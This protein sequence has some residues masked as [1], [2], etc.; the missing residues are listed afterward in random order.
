MD[1]KKSTLSIELIPKIPKGVQKD[2]EKSLLEALK[3][4]PD[5]AIAVLSKKVATLS[6]EF[7]K[8]ISLG[9]KKNLDATAPSGAASS[10]IKSIENVLK[11]LEKVK[12]S[13]AS[14]AAK[15]S[16]FSSLSREI[17]TMVLELKSA[18]SAMN[19]FRSS[20]AK[21]SGRRRQVTDN[22]RILSK[23]VLDSYRRPSEETIETS[24][25]GLSYAKGSLASIIKPSE[26]TIE[27]AS[28]GKMYAAQ[29][30]KEIEDAERSALSERKKQANLGRRMRERVEAIARRSAAEVEENE[31]RLDEKYKLARAKQNER[32]LKRADALVTKTDKVNAAAREERQNTVNANARRRMAR[33]EEFAPAL[34]SAN[35]ID[36]A[37]MSTRGLTKRQIVRAER[38]YIEAQSRPT[39]SSRSDQIL[40]A[41]R[42]GASGGVANDL[43]GRVSRASRSAQ[44]YMSSGSWSQTEMSE[45]AL[46]RR[47]TG[48]ISYD[49]LGRQI[50]LGGSGRRSRRSGGFG[51]SVTNAFSTIGSYMLA[52]APYMAAG[53]M[54]RPQ[55]GME[56]QQ[57][58]SR[59]LALGVGGDPNSITGS[60]DKLS[61]AIQEVARTSGLA[62]RD[63][64]DL[65]LAIAQSGVKGKEAEDALRSLS[66]ATKLSFGDMDA[67]TLVSGYMAMKG[68]FF[69][70]NANPMAGKDAARAMERLVVMANA[71]ATDPRPLLEAVTRIGASAKTG[72]FTLDDLEAMLAKGK[73]ISGNDPR[74]LANAMKRTLSRFYGRD[75]GAKLKEEFGIDTK[76]ENGNLRS[77]ADIWDDLSKKI[78]EYGENGEKAQAVMAALTAAGSIQATHIITLAKAWQEKKEVLDKTADSEAKLAEQMKVANNTAA[79][80]LQ[81]LDNAITALWGHVAQSSTDLGIFNDAIGKAVEILV[82]CPYQT[83]A[84]G[85]YGVS[86]AINI[87]ASAAFKAYAPIGAV[88][89]GLKLLGTLR[90]LAGDRLDTLGAIGMTRELDFQR[91]MQG[92]AQKV[93]AMKNIQKITGSI[94]GAPGRVENAKVSISNAA[95]FLSAHIFG[96]ESYNYSPYRSGG[97]V[98]PFGKRMSSFIDAAASGDLERKKAALMEMSGQKTIT[99]QDLEDM[100]HASGVAKLISRSTPG[101]KE[102]TEDFS[103]LV[104]VLA[105]QLRTVSRETRAQQISYETKKF[106]ASPSKSSPA[107]ILGGNIK[108]SPYAGQSPEK[109]LEFYKAKFKNID[110]AQQLAIEKAVKAGAGNEAVLMIKNKFVADR[111]SLIESIDSD[112]SGRFSSQNLAGSHGGAA[113]SLATLRKNQGV[114][115]ARIRKAVNEKLLSSDTASGRVFNVAKQKFIEIDKQLSVDNAVQGLDLEQMQDNMAATAEARISLVTQYRNVLARIKEEA[116]P[117]PGDREKKDIEKLEKFL[118]SQAEKANKASGAKASR[119]ESK[120]EKSQKEL[121]RVQ[122]RLEMAAKKEMKQNV[123]YLEMIIKGKNNIASF[124]ENLASKD[125]FNKGDLSGMIGD[126]ISGEKGILDLL[127]GK[128]TTKFHDVSTYVMSNIYPQMMTNMMG[129]SSAGGPAFGNMFNSLGFGAAQK[130][131]SSKAADAWKNEEMR[132]AGIEAEYKFNMQS[133]EEFSK[134]MEKTADKFDAAAEK[135]IKAAEKIYGPIRD[136]I[137]SALTS[138]FSGNKGGFSNIKNVVAKGFAES[139]SQKI[140]SSKMFGFGGQK[141]GSIDDFF[142]MLMNP[143]A[144]KLGETTSGVEFMN[145]APGAG[146]EAAMAML[147]AS[148]VG[149]VGGESQLVGGALNLAASSQIKKITGNKL[150][151]ASSAKLMSTIGSAIQI[152]GYAMAAKEMLKAVGI[153]TSRVRQDDRASVDAQ[154]QS[155]TDY[156]QNITGMKSQGL[157]PEMA[158]AFYKYSPSYSSIV[159]TTSKRGGLQGLLGGK[160]TS[161]TSNQLGANSIA[162]MQRM[163]YDAIKERYAMELKFSDSEFLLLS[164]KEKRL[165]ASVELEKKYGTDKAKLAEMENSATEAM[166]AA[167]KSITAFSAEIMGRSSF[168]NILAKYIE[169]QLGYSK[170]QSMIVSS[171]GKYSIQDAKKMIL[172]NASNYTLGT[173]ANGAAM[174]Y[175]GRPIGNQIA[176][177]SPV[178]KTITELMNS[179]ANTGSK[180]TAEQI[181]SMLND[182]L[183]LA[184]SQGAKDNVIALIDVLKDLIDVTNADISQ[185]ISDSEKMISIQ[186]VMSSTEATK[187]SIKEM[188][189]QYGTDFE[190]FSSN[191]LSGKTNTIG[192]YSWA[193][194]TKEINM[195]ISSL[196]DLGIVTASGS[197]SFIEQML[198]PEKRKNLLGY[199]SGNEDKTNAANSWIDKIVS[200]LSDAFSSF[201]AAG[202]AGT[203][204][205]ASI[206]GTK[207]MYEVGSTGNYYITQNFTVKSEYFGA[208]QTDAVKFLQF[209]SKSW[210]DS[211]M[212]TSVKLF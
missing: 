139:T 164:E 197:S 131:E 26:K 136:S 66:V 48:A 8:A 18:T 141:L 116:G 59:T 145:A 23:G 105:D 30:L 28:R 184:T 61:K 52:G 106:V 64:S 44:A 151:G 40:A 188:E 199:V 74:T 31:R 187:Q 150:L 109:A 20:A 202:A 107:S 97:E 88:I 119:D 62:W 147:A 104:N 124:M 86:S 10:A 9:V 43:L 165:Q 21:E 83:I 75:V 89:E 125:I 157:S 121:E 179:Y 117:N 50:P 6:K 144:A 142:N 92:S 110:D 149:G 133:H 63:L 7:E 22:I 46:R 159:K 73:E 173:Y 134:K 166:L 42:R 24:R 132:M 191:L 161:Y 148:G 168:Q 91:S 160:D 77:Q 120:A 178:R 13:T 112:L 193:E 15:N 167:Y 162:E 96:K 194:R 41:S 101:Y 212:N 143:A 37:I 190:M 36:A 200:M 79:K 2:I 82:D 69:G 39:L 127:N 81:D 111:E 80:S 67:K 93:G 196:K 114:S 177:I 152:Y 33:I 174:T 129:I 12:S 53:Y 153:G 128:M 94:M 16:M 84:A 135:Q 163:M 180:S 210:K 170:Q 100:K 185:R 137:E 76:D 87:I 60:F 85:M 11:K 203:K 204:G 95:E 156:F 47:L 17:Q 56:Y 181:M 208:S 195:T 198:D 4:G 113:A 130:V 205:G 98:S 32:I 175:N 138:L 19:A 25:R 123:D 71:T 186:N 99:P 192:G 122:E 115:T 14:G 1:T 58:L 72:G 51:R 183:S 118:N 211:G 65:S 206:D 35:P 182:E 209:L 146:Q 78:V 171:S 45:D 169:K 103:K 176:S 38:A 5:K 68:T 55:E 189:K 57:S 102:G 3:D 70:G 207:R 54:I 90:G 154:N 126:E 27:A 29:R 201:N 158:E 155:I 34:Y 108:T 140:M 49:E 172:D